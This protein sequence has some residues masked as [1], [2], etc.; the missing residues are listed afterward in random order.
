MENQ[1]CLNKARRLIVPV[2]FLSYP[3]IALARNRSIASAT[4]SLSRSSNRQ[5]RTS[6][7]FTGV[8]WSSE[9]EA[10]PFSPAW[11]VMIARGASPALSREEK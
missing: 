9:I 2:R 1:F 11:M 3:C 6:V 8:R 10:V 4:A 7:V 5:F